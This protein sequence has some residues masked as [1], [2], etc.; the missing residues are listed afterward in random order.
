MTWITFPKDL[1]L[2]VAVMVSAATRPLALAASNMMPHPVD[3]GLAA[4]LA[5]GSH[6]GPLGHCTGQGVRSNNRRGSDDLRDRAG[7]AYWQSVRD[8]GAQSRAVPKSAR[9]LSERDR[10]R[11]DMA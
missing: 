2:Y 5:G 7:N 8:G 11:P 9:E 6:R 1:G 3:I 4:L 10:P